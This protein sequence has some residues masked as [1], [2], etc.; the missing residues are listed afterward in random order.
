MLKSLA[1]FGFYCN[2]KEKNDWR[3]VY[4]AALYVGKNSNHKFQ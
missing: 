4:N 2:Y 1:K 3:G